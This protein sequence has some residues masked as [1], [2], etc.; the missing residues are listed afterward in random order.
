MVYYGTYDQIIQVM[1]N[2]KIHSNEKLHQCIHGRFRKQL[3]YI[4]PHMKKIKVK[5]VVSRIQFLSKHTD[6][7]MHVKPK[8]PKPNTWTPIAVHIWI[9]SLQFCSYQQRQL[10]FHTSTIVCSPLMFFRWRVGWRRVT[11][12]R[13]MA[14]WMQRTETGM[15]G[16]V[17]GMRMMSTGMRG[18]DGD[19]FAAVMADGCPT[20][21][22]DLS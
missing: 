2:Y 9:I 4:S 1:V 11:E 3:W 14:T 8:L 16:T 22:F 17:M 12:M 13:R 19:G 10:C 7:W 15:R 5:I 20:E 18:G 21:W 6:Q